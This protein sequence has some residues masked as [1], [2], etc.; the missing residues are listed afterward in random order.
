MF[1]GGRGGEGD[2]RSLSV[3]GAVGSGT[4][5]REDLLRGGG[6]HSGR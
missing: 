3:E 6:R 4:G 5:L 1:G 2:G